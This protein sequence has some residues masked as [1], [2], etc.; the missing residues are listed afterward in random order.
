MRARASLIGSL[1]A[2]AALAS[3]VAS[4]VSGCGGSDSGGKRSGGGSGGSGNVFG[5]G[6]GSFGGAS[7]TCATS[8][9]C[10]GAQVCD[11][12]M[13]GC[14]TPIGKCTGH[15]DCTTGSYCDTAS[16]NCLPA[17]VGNPC[18]TDANCNAAACVGG[19]CQCVGSV[20]R[21]EGA[22]FLDIY[23]ILDRTSSMGTD[24]AYVQG[25]TPPVASK[26]CYATYAVPD[27]LTSVTPLVPTTFAFQF[28]SQATQCDGTAYSTPLSGPTQLP[29]TAS[30]PIIQAISAETFA[31]GL[32]TDIEGALRG[33]AAYTTA[34]RKPGHAMIG[35]LMTD[36]DPNRCEQSIPALATI[37]SDHLAQTGIKTF[38][39][40]MTG[41]TDANLEQLG[42]AGGADPHSDYCGSVAPP[43]HYWNVGDGSADAIKSALSAIVKQSTPLPCNYAVSGLTPPAGQAMD[44]SKVNVTLTQGDGGA[45]VIGRVSSAA[46]CPATTPA[47]YYDNPAAPTTINLCKTACDLVTAATNGAQVN[48]AV[49]CQ[50]TVILR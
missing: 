39:I 36:G 17:S 20:A 30:D 37:M 43:C 33:I 34:S 41:A 15:G 38:I 11:A 5:T 29:M 45:T 35:V 44:Y 6:G 49:G 21:Q 13:H 42:A 12:F 16:G 27:Y 1:A 7:G 9:D 3:A 50:E 22:G 47:W 26:A 32:G 14:V 8:A 2:A 4:L 25:S 40:G 10:T 48:V 24:C 19:V 46:S 18:A 28:M 31:G 23:F